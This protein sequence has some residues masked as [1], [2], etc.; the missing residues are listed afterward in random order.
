MIVL[1]LFTIEGSALATGRHGLAAKAAAE[2]IA[3]KQQLGEYLQAF[4]PEAHDGRGDATFT[5][6]K[7]KA[8]R[9]K[10][11]EAAHKCWLTQSKT[12]PLRPDGKPNRPLTAFNMTFE[13]T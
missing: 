12:R 9:F 2:L 7:S 11:V 3:G 4:D 13:K 6:D 10:S 1:R 5:P 8:K